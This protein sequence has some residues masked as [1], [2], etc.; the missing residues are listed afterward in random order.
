MN[1][2]SLKELG[3]SDSIALAKVTAV[4]LPY[5]AGL[6]AFI[7][8][9]MEGQTDLIY[10]GRAKNLEKRVFGDIFGGQGK[11]SMQKIHAK[12]FDEGYLGKLEISWM[13]ADKLKA[14]K[15]DLLQKFKQEHGA[16]PSWNE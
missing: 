14:R 1:S 10:I 8:K 2:T 13:P 4:D 6:F 11:K 5:Q 3:F 12:L 7:D 15:A 9:S 16:Y